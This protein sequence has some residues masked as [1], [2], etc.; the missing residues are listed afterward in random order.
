MCYVF[1]CCLVF[2]LLS[3]SYVCLY[4]YISLSLFGFL[5]IHSIIMFLLSVVLYMLLSFSHDF[6]WWFGFLYWFICCFVFVSFIFDLCVFMCCFLI[7]L[8]VFFYLVVNSCI[9]VCFLFMYVVVLFIYPCCFVLSLY[10]VFPFRYYLLFCHSFNV[11]LLYMFVCYVFNL[12]LFCVVFYL[13]IVVFV[14]WSRINNSK[15]Y[16]NENNK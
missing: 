5:C 9:F 14:F 8:F 7:C 4:I 16:Y 11:F 6:V 15:V 3:F 12:S 10:V 2:H 1:I 13:F